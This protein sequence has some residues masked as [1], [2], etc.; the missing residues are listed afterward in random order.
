MKCRIISETFMEWLIIQFV[1]FHIFRSEFQKASHWQKIPFKA[2]RKTCGEEQEQMHKQDEINRATFCKYSK[3]L[4]ENQFK[5]FE[6]SIFITNMMMMNSS[7]NTLNHIESFLCHH[8]S[9]DCKYICIEYYFTICSH[10]FLTFPFFFAIHWWWMCHP[11]K[12]ELFAG[13][14]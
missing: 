8:V 11:F 9:F 13:Y 7:L 1:L 10:V 12:Y 4:H 5:P 3:H 2:H 14:L 6:M